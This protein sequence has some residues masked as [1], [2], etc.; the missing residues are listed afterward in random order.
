MTR[1]RRLPENARAL[2]LK[3]TPAEELALQV[4]EGRRRERSEN[5]DSPSE[6]VADALWY[7]LQ[8]KEGIGKEKVESLLPPTL[9]DEVKTNLRKFPK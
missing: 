3:L 5:R 8:N 6:I 4:I 9:S 1:K 2:T 7:F